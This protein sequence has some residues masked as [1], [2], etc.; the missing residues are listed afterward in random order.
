[1][2]GRRVQRNPWRA[3]LVVAVAVG[4]L[5]VAPGPAGAQVSAI[6][7]S[8]LPA[9]ISNVNVGDQN[10][11]ALISITNHSI[12]A[13]GDVNVTVSNIRL[14]PSCAASG[15]VACAT[16]EPRPTA[17]QPIFNVDPATGRAGTS[18][19]GI[20]FSVSAPDAFGTVT[21]T[22]S[23]PVIL[24][25]VSL[26]G[27]HTSCMIDFTFDVVQRPQ[28]GV[29]TAFLAAN[30]SADGFGSTTVTGVSSPISVAAPV[31]R[32]VNDFD[33]T[34]STDVAVFRPAS[35]AWYLR[36]ANPSVVAWGQE[37]DIP[38]PGDYDGSGTVDIAV[39]R[40]ANN[41]WYIRTPTPQFVLWGEAGDIPVPADYDSNGTTD[42]A[43]FR[44]STG[45]WYLRTAAPLAV[46][47]GHAGDIP[48]PADYDGNGTT[49]IAV[50]R[51]AMG[52]WYLRTATSQFVQWG[53]AGDIP[54]P[55]DYDGNGAADVA[56]FRPST[57]TWYLRTASP[58]AVSWGS[59]GD[60]PSPGDYDGNGTTDL[61]VFRPAN[62]AWYIRTPTPQFVLWGEGGD[63]ALSLPDAIRRFF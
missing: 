42:I 63:K 58:T 52:T 49:D 20:L 12:G 15:A 24:A 11:P 30:V 13:A 22:P 53:Q 4:W 35:G 3:L 36:T 14:H 21:F 45:T 10:K 9:F 55:G 41:A 16:P 34:G 54:T 56:I 2:K 23:S 6:A 19:A 8:A 60:V 48:V 5:G 62:S 61:A 25:A 59:S 47:W 57:G 32:R 50:F 27:P 33:G 43:I 1:V 37:G 51:P 26:G 18:C 38:V 31:G 46:V 40:P 39:F 28:D 44:P 7:A 29:T 17:A